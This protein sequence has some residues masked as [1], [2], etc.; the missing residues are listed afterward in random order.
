[1]HPGDVV[2]HE[3]SGETWTVAAVSLDGQHLIC[4]GWPETM[5]KVAECTLI[6]A[7]GPEDRRLMSVEVERQCRGQIRSAW[8]RDWL[9]RNPET[10]GAGGGEGEG[11]GGGE[12]GGA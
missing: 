3:P 4:C 5:A 2:R 11:G 8:A 12:G 9:E 6:K 10:V 1:M 7:A